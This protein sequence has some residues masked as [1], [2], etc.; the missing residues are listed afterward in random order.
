MAVRE[1]IW[2][3]IDVGKAAHHA[4]AVDE[5]GKTVFS[6]RVANTQAATEQLIARADKT[7][8]EV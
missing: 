5:T 3:G 2:I 8:V 4:C 6:Q 1:K 7:A